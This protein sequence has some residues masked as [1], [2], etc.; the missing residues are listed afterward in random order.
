MVAART[1]AA[2]TATAVALLPVSTAAATA[3]ATWGER[4]VS[5]VMRHH[6]GSHES[7]PNMGDSIGRGP[8]AGT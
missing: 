6:E 4:A 5:A 7:P 3:A 1:T 2:A 8:I